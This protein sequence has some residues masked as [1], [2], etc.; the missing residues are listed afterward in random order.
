MEQYLFSPVRILIADDF[1][2]W[3]R[4]VL[5]LFRARPEWQVIAEAADGP[6]AIRK[7]EEL[8]PDLIVLDI[9]LPKSKQ[10]STPGNT[11][12]TG[13]INIFQFGKMDGHLR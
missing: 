7:A 3:Q 1:K 12:T 6:E 4:Q 8:K 5:S 9:G 13:F 10:T 2:D 11:H